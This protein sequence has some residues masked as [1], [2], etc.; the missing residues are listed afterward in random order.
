VYDIKSHQPVVCGRQRGN[1]GYLAGVSAPPV[2]DLLS[3]EPWWAKERRPSPFFD[4]EKEQFLFCFPRFR[5]MIFRI[6]D[7][8]SDHAIELAN[9][10]ERV[11]QFSPVRG[12]CFLGV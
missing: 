6:D 12:K 7:N 3:F 4:L 10:R 9:R 11:A 2:D 5:W 1:G 8:W